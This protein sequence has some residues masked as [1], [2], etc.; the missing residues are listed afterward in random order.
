ML[1]LIERFAQL[2]VGKFKVEVAL[3]LRLNDQHWQ[4][5]IQD[6]GLGAGSWLSVTKWG[7]VPGEYLMTEL[8]EGEKAFGYGGW[9]CSPAEHKEWLCVVAGREAI[10]RFV[11]QRFRCASKRAQL[12]YK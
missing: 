12:G 5:I 4:G 9:E 2:A 1:G 10:W 7:A 8:T 11:E 3:S 6:W